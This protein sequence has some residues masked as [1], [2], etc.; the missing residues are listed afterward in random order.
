MR[1]LV[2]ILLFLIS[3]HSAHAAN[4]QGTIYD[5]GLN[6]I[7][8][9]ILVIN[10]K[11]EQTIVLRESNYKLNLPNGNY[12]IKA[13]YYENGFLEAYADEELEI[14]GD[15]NYTLDLILFPSL[16][17]EDI[18]LNQSDFEFES[19]VGLEKSI[20]TLFLVAII[21]AI[22]L[23]LIFKFR[24]KYSKV[25][26]EKELGSKFDDILLTN[27]L[28]V[29]RKHDGRVTQKEIRKELKLSEAKLSLVL[30]Q[31]EGEGKIKK[32][33]KGRGNII[34]LSK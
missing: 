33:K 22:I 4:V 31:L 3:V 11:P 30:A 32:I 29:I 10:T 5:I 25:D 27:V 6:K 19:D 21:L 12:K 2:L 23:F 9:S 34:I 7:E 14:S 16:S 28:D 20:P 15:G 17:E 18:L 24:K 13:Y 8:N 1:K 26:L